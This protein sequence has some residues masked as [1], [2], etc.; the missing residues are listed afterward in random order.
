MFHFPITGSND[1][2]ECSRRKRAGK[3]SSA[4]AAMPNTSAGA[5]SVISLFDGSVQ[6]LF[7]GSS[8][9]GRNGGPD[10]LMLPPSVKDATRR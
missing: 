9:C 8:R 3:D 7:D 2:I 4:S 10:A 5:L 6:S 1:G